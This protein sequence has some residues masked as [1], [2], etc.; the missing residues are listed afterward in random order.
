MGWH[1]YKRHVLRTRC[2]KSA[3]VGRLVISRGKSLETEKGT[4]LVRWK[5]WPAKYDSWIPAQPRHGTNKNIA[6]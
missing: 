3:S 1:A 2:T 6:P 5:G 4:V